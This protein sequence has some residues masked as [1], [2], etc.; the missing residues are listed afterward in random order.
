MQQPYMLIA[1]DDQDDQFLLNAAFR[2]SSLAVQVHF[3]QNGKEVLRHLEGIS[4]NS[5]LPDLIVLDLNMPLLDG[6]QTLLRLK[7]C[8]RYNTIPVIILTTSLSE[9]E[10]ADCLR[11]G[12]ANFLFKPPGYEKILTTARYLYE[13]S[14]AAC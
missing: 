3:V 11:L 9:K 7:S 12:A 2:E 5:R 8:A 6:R 1:E 14:G 13:L 10:K 4:D